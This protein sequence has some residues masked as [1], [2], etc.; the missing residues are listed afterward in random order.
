MQQCNMIK[1]VYIL[2]WIN[3]MKVVKEMIFS[4]NEIE[5]LFGVFYYMEICFRVLRFVIIIGFSLMCL[6]CLFYCIVVLFIGLF[7]NI[8]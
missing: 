5:N 1:V 6:I 2:D 8:I 7:I 3:S 4:K